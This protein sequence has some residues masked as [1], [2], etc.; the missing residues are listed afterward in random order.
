MSYSARRVVEYHQ[1]NLSQIWP[2]VPI[3]SMSRVDAT[4]RGVMPTP[5]AH[6]LTAT[7]QPAM[8]A[9]EDVLCEGSSSLSDSPPDWLGE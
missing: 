3:L 9:I 4:T 6:E 2:L 1:L 8:I 5:K 7:L